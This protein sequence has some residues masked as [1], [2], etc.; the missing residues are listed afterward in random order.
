MTH[1]TTTPPATT[2]RPPTTTVVT[3]TPGITVSLT[4][5]FYVEVSWFL[6]GGIVINSFFL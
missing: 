5:T 1:P 3:T 2:T 6:R 4:V